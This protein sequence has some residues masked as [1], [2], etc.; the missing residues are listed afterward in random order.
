MRDSIHVSGPLTIS[1]PEKERRWN[2]YGAS[3]LRHGLEISITGIEHIEPCEPRRL[4]K[5][6]RR[7]AKKNG[8]NTSEFRGKSKGRAFSARGQENG[9]V[10]PDP[11]PKE[12]A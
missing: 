4:V 10:I 5:R 2:A 7:V 9:K 3:I 1:M 6:Q 8:Y 11:W 12:Q